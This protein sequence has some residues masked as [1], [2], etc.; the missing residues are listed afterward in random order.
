M[1]LPSQFYKP[2]AIG[3]P[4]PMREIPV[5]IERMIHFLPP[6]IE[7]M[8][9]KVAGMIAQVDVILG[10]LEDAIPADDK[11]AAREGFI[12]MALAHDYGSTG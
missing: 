2:L 11:I 12:E 10:N 4:D 1:K 7:K 6:Q 9:N 5:K 8:R 3:A